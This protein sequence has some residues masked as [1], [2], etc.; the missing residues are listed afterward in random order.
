LN[1]LYDHRQVEL[2]GFK[3]LRPVF[4]F[5]FYFMITLV[6]CL[7]M[8][9]KRCIGVRIES[10]HEFVFIEPCRADKVPEPIAGNKP[11]V[12]PGSAEMAGRNQSSVRGMHC[13]AEFI[14]GFLSFLIPAI[15][16]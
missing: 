4:I 8:S 2:A 6:L 16:S 1:I 12:E 7:R 13:F 5:G 10:P 3:M 14:S 11:M 9:M 15:E